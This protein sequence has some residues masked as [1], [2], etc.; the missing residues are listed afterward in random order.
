MFS[1]SDRFDPTFSDI[2]TKKNRRFRYAP[3]ASKRFDEPAHPSSVWNDI[4]GLPNSW[5]LSWAK[6]KTSRPFAGHANGCGGDHMFRGLEPNVGMGY[7][8][9]W[10]FAIVREDKAYM[11]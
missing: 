1:S 11:L 7:S 4:E 5:K 9:E 2:S 10:M 3:S 8:K 6:R